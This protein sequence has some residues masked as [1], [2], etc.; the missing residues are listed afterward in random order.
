MCCYMHPMYT[1]IYEELNSNVLAVADYKAFN[2]DRVEQ[3]VELV[4]VKVSCC[5]IS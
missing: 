2:K 4:N 5:F 1:G 3:L